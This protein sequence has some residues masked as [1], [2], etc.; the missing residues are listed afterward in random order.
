[1]S[2]YP[3]EQTVEIDGESVRY[4]GLKDGKFSSGNFS[5]PSDKP[6]FIPAETI[7]L[8]LDNLSALIT[9]GGGEPNN[10]G[11]NQ[12]VSLL[13][14]A[15]TA[16]KIVQRDSNG[17]AQFASPSASADAATKSYVDTHAA[18]TT[19]HGAV[20]TA[21]ASTMVV[22]NASGRAQFADPSASA[23]AAT[24]GYVMGWAMP[25]GAIYIQF[26]GQSEP[27]TLWPGTTWSNI[28]SDTLLAGRVP[29]IEGSA[30]YG[31]AA[32]F[33]SK[34]DDQVQGFQY[35]YL[36]PNVSGSTNGPFSAADGVDDTLGTGAPVAYSSY[37]TPR[38]G[39]E[40]R[41]ASTTVRVW[42]RTA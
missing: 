15:A 9:A 8:I 28:S 12:L 3:D 24:K 2:M 35:N 5:D 6:S 39:A 4:P 42:K 29:R 19:A 23:D 25:V 38:I 26:G 16:L 41:A 13:A 33:G 10:S 32:A 1:M 20:S 34:Q 40:T 22:R 11:I 21:T 27:G 17:R 14:S 31:S 36:H 30:T 37:G 7:N 18:L